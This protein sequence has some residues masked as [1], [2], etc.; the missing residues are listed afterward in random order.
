MVGL[1]LLSIVKPP[2]VITMDY[3]FLTNFLMMVLVR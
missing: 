1:V 3:L 2:L